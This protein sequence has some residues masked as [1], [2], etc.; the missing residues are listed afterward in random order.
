MNP[1][2]INI[3]IGLINGEVK[4]IDSDLRRETE[5]KGTREERKT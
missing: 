5:R 3:N 2:A 1:Q 4:M